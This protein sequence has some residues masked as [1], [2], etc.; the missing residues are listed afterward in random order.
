MHS[1][2]LGIWNVVFR[3]YGAW[4]K[5]QNMALTQIRSC[6]DKILNFQYGTWELSPTQLLPQPLN[7]RLSELHEHNCDRTSMLC[8]NNHIVK[9]PPPSQN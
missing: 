5:V 8:F 7:L 4:D 2:L 3:A 6:W 1:L 9:P